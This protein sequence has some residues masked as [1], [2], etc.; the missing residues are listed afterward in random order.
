MSSLTGRVAVVT[1]A[2]RGIGAAAASRLAAAGARV[3]GI[4]RSGA[5]PR[6]GITHLQCDLTDARAWDDI[7]ARL[8]REFG[9]PDI[10]VSNAGN[11]LLKP[12]SDTTPAEFASSLAINL[13]APFGLARLLAPA[14]RARGGRFIHVGSVADH[15]AF[16]GNG[17]YAAAKFGLRALHEVLSAEYAGTGVQFSLVSP[18][19]TDTAIW[20]GVNTEGAGIPGRAGMLRPD[21][22][23]DAIVFVA[24]RPPHVLIDWLRLGPVPQP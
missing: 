5:G 8:L 10:V 18:G 13:Q 22:V 6:D 7:G 12:V 1:G 4:S 17:A 21:D 20:D 16:P 11:F 23:A 3:I 2:S 9:T 14:M 19:P 15:L 24:S